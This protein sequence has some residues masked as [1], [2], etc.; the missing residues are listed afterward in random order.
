MATP[1]AVSGFENILRR[2]DTVEFDRI[3]RKRLGEASLESE[4]QPRIDLLRARI[5]F[6]Y[7]YKDL[8]SDSTLSNMGSAFSS[9]A[10]ELVSQASRNDAEFL[11]S[12]ADFLRRYDGTV[13]QLLGYWPALVTTAIETSGFLESSGAVLDGIRKE[14][15]AAVQEIRRE[16]DRVISQAQQL[17]KDIESRTFDSIGHFGNSCTGSIQRSSEKSPK[18]SDTLVNSQCVKRGRFHYFWSPLDQ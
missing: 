2:V 11:G 3:V 5:K 7:K 6:A 10:N 1:E 8:L 4:F 14:G 13:D 16:A 18:P 17:A 9:I 12:K 15:G